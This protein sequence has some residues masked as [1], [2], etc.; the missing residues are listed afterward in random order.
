MSWLENL[1]RPDLRALAPYSSARTEAGDAVVSIAVDAN[2]SPWPAFGNLATQYSVNRYPEPQPPTLRGRLASIYGVKS[3]QLLIGRGSDEAIDLLLRL[4]CR[5][6]QDEI[7]ICP[8]T[9]GMYKVSA[10]V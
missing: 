1:V 10:E 4:L 3:E 5:A 6:G 7:I 2:E 9:Y 8:P